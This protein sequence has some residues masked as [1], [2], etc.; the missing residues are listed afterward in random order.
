[1]VTSTL[2][3]ESLIAVLHMAILLLATC[4][5]K[6]TSGEQEQEEY[7]LWLDYSTLIIEH[8]I[9][10]TKK[11]LELVTELPEGKKIA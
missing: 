7:Y 11:E 10:L 5:N 2:F 3:K 1:M 9:I 6:Q 8:A 4:S